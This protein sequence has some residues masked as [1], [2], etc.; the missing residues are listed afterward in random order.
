MTLTETIPLM[1]IDSKNYRE[2]QPMSSLKSMC[3]QCALNSSPAD[4]LQAVKGAAK[5]AFGSDCS[6][7]GRIYEEIKDV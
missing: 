3:I 4:C 2:I 6:D 7:N 1:R 5:K